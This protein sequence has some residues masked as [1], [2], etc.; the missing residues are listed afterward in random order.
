MR[1]IKFIEIGPCVRVL[2]PNNSP[3]IGLASVTWDPNLGRKWPLTQKLSIIG[4][5]HLTISRSLLLSKKP[6]LEFWQ[7]K[8]KCNMRARVKS[9][10]H[11]LNQGGGE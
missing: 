4:L 1:S 10:S 8:I 6:N 9:S 5:W 7:A 3:F 11:K 2:C